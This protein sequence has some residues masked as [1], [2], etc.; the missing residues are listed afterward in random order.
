MIILKSAVEIEKMRVLGDV[1]AGIIQSLKK[2]SRPGVTTLE[3]DGLAAEL[4]KEHGAKSGSYGY[5]GFP[6]HLCISLNETIVHG[7]PSKRKLMDGDLVSLDLVLEREG[8]YVDGGL[9]FVAGKSDAEK[10]RLLTICKQALDMGMAQ[11][12][13]GKHIGDIGHAIQTHVEAAG[14]SVVR[15]FIGHGVGRSMHEDPQVPNYG[16]TGTGPKIVPG[17]TLAIEPMIAQGAWE[18]VVGRDGWTANMADGK[19]SCYFE[20]TVAVTEDEPIILTKKLNG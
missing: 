9:S 14:Y 19:L 6:G 8:V 17:M 11:A 4:A 5:R 20:H 13:P 1:L 3:L 18:V 2:E 15:E 16:K 10:E 12:K 7:I